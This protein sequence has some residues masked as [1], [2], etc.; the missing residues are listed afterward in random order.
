M[1]KGV[2]YGPHAF[3]VQLRDLN[4]HQLLNGVSTGDIGPK[5]GWHAIDNGYLKLSRSFLIIFHFFKK[6]I[7]THFSIILIRSC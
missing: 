1:I 6:K 7:L 3:I 5:M 4:N 2:D